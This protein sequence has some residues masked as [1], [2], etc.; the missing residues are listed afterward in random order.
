MKKVSVILS[1]AVL[2]NSSIFMVYGKQTNNVIK[3]SAI[4]QDKDLK[5]LAPFIDAV[6]KKIPTAPGIAVAIVR[7]DKTVFL[8]GFGYRNLQAKLPVTPQTQFYIASTTKS[9]TGT[10]AKMLADE[11]KIDLDAP[12]KTYFP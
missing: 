7:G 11:G 2:F 5:K 1:I 6:M 8:Q 12:V 9:F 4:S 3:N 10:A